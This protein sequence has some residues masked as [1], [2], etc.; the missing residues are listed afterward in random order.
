MA[1][2]L[3]V[4]I[5]V[6]VLL[7]LALLFA[8]GRGGGILV[9]LLA[10][11][12]VGGAGVFLLAGRRAT[13][14]AVRPVPVAAPAVVAVEIPVEAGPSRAL[15]G[16]VL[17][18][19]EG[20]VPFEGAVVAGPADA[21]ATA[22]ADGRFTIE[23]L[24]PGDLRLRA[25]APG[26][27]GASVKVPA[28]QADD[29][30]LRL[31][32]GA[33]AAGKVLDRE[34]RAPVAGAAVSWADSSTAVSGPDG[35][36]RVEPVPSGTAELVVKAKGFARK[37]ETI[38][39]PAAGREGI[40]ILLRPGTAATGTVFGPD[41]RPHAGAA[42]E[43][44]TLV[45]A[46]VVGTVPVPFET[47]GILS[48]AD[49]T[50][51][52]EG[53]PVGRKIRVTASTAE[54]LS[55][56]V[57][58]G[59][60]E[61]S[62]V[63]EG[64]DLRLAPAAAV[65]A[66]VLDEKGAPVAGA[67]VRVTPAN[68]DEGQRNLGM[69]RMAVRRDEGARITDERGVVRV[70][71]VAPG[72]LRVRADKDDYRRAEAVVPAGPGPDTPV[73]LTLD[74]GQ[75][76]AGKVADPAGAAVAG[77]TVTV[78][79]L[80]AANFLSETRTTGEDGS[81]RIGGL[82]GKGLM[83]RAEKAGFVTTSLNGIEAG[84]E[85]MVV[86]LQPGGAIAGVVTDPSGAP[87]T[88]FRILAHRQG[89][90]A[91]NPM[92]WQRFAAAQGGREFEDAGGRFRIEGLEP[93]T[94]EVEARAADHAPGRAAG[95]A[96]VPGKDAE[97]AVQLSA[98]LTV[99]GIVLRRSDGNPVEG[100][101]VKLPADGMFGEFDM[102]DFD[103]GGIEDEV[104]GAEQARQ[105]M[106]G[107]AKGQAFTG[108]DGRFAL[109]GLEPGKIKLMVSVKGLAPASVR[110][111]QVPSEGD[112]R[113]ELAEE[114]AVEGVV[115]DARGAPKQ[116]AM[117]MLQRLPVFMRFATTDA[118]G[119]YRIGGVGA[120]SY[121]F[122]VM[123]GAQGGAPNLN[124]KSDNVTLEE[125]KTT[126]KDHRLGEGTKVV[127]K[128]TRSRRPVGGLMVLLMPAARSGGP[129]GMLTG[130]GGGGFAM[131]STKEDGTYEISGVGPGR[132]TA[133]VQTGM[134]GAP[135][136]GEPLEVPKGA[137]EVRHDIVLPD[138]GIRGQV[139]DEEGRPVTGATVLALAAGGG[140]LTDIGSA[141]EGIGGQSFTDDEGRFSLTG[142][143]AGAWTLRVQASGFGT[144]VVENVNA[145]EGASG[146]VRVVLRRGTEVTVR[147]VGPDGS[148]V[149]GANIFLADSSGREITNISQFDAV[150]TGE[151]G[152][153]VVRAP[154][155]TI[156]FEAAA[157]G[158]SPG[159]VQ[160]EVPGGEVVIRLA[161]GAAV[162][163]VVTGA[164]GSPVAGAG[165]EV[166]DAAG[167]PYGR[168]FSMEAFA[169]LLG[170]AATGADGTW[171]RR[172]LPAG[173]WRVR[174]ALPD[175]RSGEGKA[176]LVEGET[177]TVNVAIR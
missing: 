115:T 83:L 143:K 81:F 79:R 47:E 87:A 18:G 88:S 170:G 149:A 97:V 105:V 50:Y 146:D 20:E 90:K 25:A 72:P 55:E 140:K 37:R 147:V 109:K 152:R 15:R 13:V 93:G 30:T 32:P 65:L 150:K 107:F 124:M 58:A 56:A 99:S 80:G 43:A 138:T 95:V 125:G 84:R 10:L 129:M 66:T 85:P 166:L 134:G 148:P 118:E 151:D 54:M 67:A 126:R 28:D 1:I 76:V 70:R 133:S 141:M 89:D 175:G 165:V 168:R 45:D 155:G 167:N 3:V 96:V 62:L 92:D 17:K 144:E 60:L 63:L 42:V 21:T 156:Q 46:P 106:S 111:I 145:A 157:A 68:E 31:V 61:R 49:G 119:R 94:Y 35:A 12:V 153:A 59:P 130:G 120:G 48:G 173:T 5:G 41:G 74:A 98:G 159:E 6:V 104:G 29:V 36:F 51:R 113:V 121:L 77:A 132:Y 116:G 75:A 163:V 164:N 38:K 172:D 44:A 110:G 162:K 177:A 39:V 101:R 33:W 4:V 24:P 9:G 102:G 176:V 174:A 64:V 160:A 53:L 16:R 122:Y 117:V 114:S 57:E 86:T 2:S 169:D 139:V 11:L 34:T 112:V 108:A 27:A 154:P 123:E 8:G 69:M 22:G 142:M 52:I 137:V 71:P 19:A 128:V 14:V 40:E 78:Q 127:G 158:F 7:G 135:S 161:K 131:G 103:L 136:G 91:A 26:F 171:T 100:A 82:D 23:G 73:T